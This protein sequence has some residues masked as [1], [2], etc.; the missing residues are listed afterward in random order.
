MLV[1]ILIY[2]KKDSNSKND[3]SLKTECEKNKNSS[4]RKFDDLLNYLVVCKLGNI[5]NNDDYKPDCKN[6]SQAK[7][8]LLL[9]LHKHKGKF[10]L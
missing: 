7:E 4:Q 9:E 8:I 3:S 5:A 1:I 6:I 10:Y 2:L